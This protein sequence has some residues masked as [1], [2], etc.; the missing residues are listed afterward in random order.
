MSELDDYIA[1]QEHELLAHFGYPKVHT[2]TRV[3]EKGTPYI[4]FVNVCM[5]EEG[6]A[7]FLTTDLPLAI[8]TFKEKVQSYIDSKVGVIRW[9]Q[10]PQI[11]RV[12]MMVVDDAD[13]TKHTYYKVKARLVVE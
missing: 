2:I 8:E 13:Q 12:S 3:T 4:S 5:K 6:R 11:D 10:L 9:R 7:C 1:S